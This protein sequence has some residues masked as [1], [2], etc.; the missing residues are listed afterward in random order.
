MPQNA[1]FSQKT[2]LCNNDFRNQR[3][4][5]NNIHNNFLTELGRAEYFV[6][7]RP[8]FTPRNLKICQFLHRCKIFDLY[9]LP[10]H[11][12]PFYRTTSLV[13]PESNSYLRNV[14]EKTKSS[15]I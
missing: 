2:E 12:T 3:I 4:H 1:I 6:L 7:P 9:H 5:D 10:I 8:V 15:K 11:L 14:A 13:F